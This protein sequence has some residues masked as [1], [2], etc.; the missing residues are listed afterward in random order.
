[1]TI[2]AIA[3]EA[4]DS[5]EQPEIKQLSWEKAKYLE[6]LQRRVMRVQQRL[7]DTSLSDEEYMR[8]EELADHLT[9]EMESM[10]A[11]HIISVPQSWLAYGVKHTPDWNQPGSLGVLERARVIELMKLVNGVKADEDA[12]N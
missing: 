12:K 11:G 7:G 9:S 10:I 1:M 6:K 5:Q 2:K 3:T 4:D 8:A